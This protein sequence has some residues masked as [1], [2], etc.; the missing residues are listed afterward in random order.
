M[1]IV[2][3]MTRNVY[4]KILPSLRSLAEW[5]PDAH[6]YILAEDDTL[7]FDLPIKCKIIN[8]SNQTMFNNSVNKKNRFGGYIN[9][10]KV[11]YPTLLPKLDKV[12]HL[13]QDTIICDRL[14]DF[15]NI[16]VT[17]KWFASVPE[18]LAKHG[19][20]HL[21]GDTYYNMGVSLINLK[22]MRKDKIEDVMAQYLIDVEQPFAD[23]DAWNKYGIEQN[24]VVPVPLRFNE[25]MS[26]GYTDN[27]AIV[28]YCGISDWYENRSI[29]RVEYINKYRDTTR[30]Y[31][32]HVCNDREWY[33]HDYMIPDMIAHGIDA[34]NIITWIDNLEVGNLDSFVA[35]CE[36]IGENLEPYNSTW[37]I[38][39]DV[40]LSD[41][42][43][44][45]AE[46]Q[47]SGFAN[48]FCNEQFDGE[49]TNYIG[50]TTTSGMWFSFQCIL[51][52]NAIAKRFAEW[53]KND[54][55]PNN[56]FPEYV[57]TGKCDDS[58][59]REYTM[60]H[61]PSAS[62]LNIF[63]NVADHIDYL[64]GGTVINKHRLGEFRK[65]YWR[66]EV[67]DDAVRKLEKKLK[68]REAKHGKDY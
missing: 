48:A 13:D 32:I 14:D 10:L 42:F 39:D 5:H 65:S 47:Y 1:N 40:V 37:H 57:S 36:W 46:K 26:T 30:K 55:V 7:P 12:I 24:K 41:R 63:P 16:D 54:C 49:R 2:Y 17:G 29:K 15:W 28:H 21:F 31:M 35:S 44:E 18:Y 51:I 9:L 23:Q 52:P 20:E 68:Q 33:V 58:L 53:F 11:Y 27:P 19:R 4:K 22:Q 50:E 59:F 61:E 45:I 67:L 25:N 56:L 64:I 38:Q 43:Y 3:A 8:I 34:K 62:A 66:D 60:A 6:V